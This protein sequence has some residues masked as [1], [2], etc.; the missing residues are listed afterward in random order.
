MR[1]LELPKINVGIILSSIYPILVFIDLGT[2]NGSR[3][4]QTWSMMLGVGLFIYYL[5]QIAKVHSYLKQFTNSEYPISPARSIWLTV[6]PFYNIYGIPK[7]T[8]TIADFINNNSEEVKMKRN[9]AAII[10]IILFITAF[11]PLPFGDVVGFRIFNVFGMLF[12]FLLLNNMVKKIRSLVYYES[13]NNNFEPYEKISNKTSILY[14][15]SSTI[16]NKGPL[17]YFAGIAIL[18]AINILSFFSASLNILTNTF[19]LVFSYVIFPIVWYVFSLRLGIDKGISRIILILTS[20]S[21]ILMA[22]ILSVI[23][24]LVFKFMGYEK[25][26]DFI[27]D[28]DSISYYNLI[29]VLMPNAFVTIMLLLRRKK[30][31]NN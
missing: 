31:V 12:Y 3:I 1:K 14:K 2:Q 18:Y 24:A 20:M 22:I 27:S 30:N 4:S 15:W 29:L 10:M 26:L 16:N 21:N 6:I 9:S 8:N 28:N 11:I 13:N 5:Y 23:F 7:W 17:F 25:Y 19:F